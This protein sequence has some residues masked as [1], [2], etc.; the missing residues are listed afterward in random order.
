[1]KIII[2]WIGLPHYAF[3]LYIL[4]TEWKRVTTVYIT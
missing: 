1:M 2:G 3:I 4:W